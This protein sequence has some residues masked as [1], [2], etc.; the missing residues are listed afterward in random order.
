MAARS[1]INGK[2]RLSAAEAAKDRKGE[3]LSGSF[4][5]FLAPLKP[6]ISEVKE[7]NIEFLPSYNALSIMLQ[8]S[9]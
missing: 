2:R 4:K 3:G 9:L 7:L 5:D 8:N 1:R 6:I